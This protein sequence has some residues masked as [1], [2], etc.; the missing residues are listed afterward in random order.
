MMKR[1]QPLLRSVKSTG[2]EKAEADT[3]SPALYAR[4]SAL[5]FGF[6]AL[7]TSFTAVVLPARIL[8][9]AP[10][11]SKNS[12]LGVL[13]F[14]GLMIAMA[15]QPMA[16]AFSDHVRTRWGRRRPL[17]IVGAIATVPFLIMAGVASSYALLFVSVCLLQAASNIALGPYGALIRDLV[18]RARRGTAS[19]IKVFVEMTGA[20][21]LTAAVGLLIGQ[22]AA[23]GG[24]GWLWA[25]LAI[26]SCSLGIGAIITVASIREPAS[27]VV[28]AEGRAEKPQRHARADYW[29]FLLSRLFT[30]LALGSLQSYAFFFLK[31]VIGVN[32]PARVT[33]MLIL[34]VG[35]AVLLVTYPAGMLADRVGRKPLMVAAVALGAVCSVALL[36]AS[37][38]A[39]LLGIGAMIGGAMGMFL[40]SSWAMATDLVSRE[41]AAQQLGFL[42]LATAGGAGMARLNGLWVD[43]LN[44]HGGTLGYSTLI[45][46]CAILFIMAMVLILRIRSRE[47]IEESDRPIA[48]NGVV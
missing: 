48:Q 44:S 38:V 30:A 32:N 12:Y 29:W 45:S 34:V 9:I 31:D 28:A 2:T 26:L 39:T 41:R 46:L 20:V 5:G 33:G 4:I 24:S 27:Q 19:G 21:I 40:G 42:N 3:D 23:G 22:E 8:E 47:R 10:P 37:S 17:I 1:L 15:V 18:P 14:V 11:G 36:G 16:G 6:T 35:A 25:S 13:T 7:A 43:R